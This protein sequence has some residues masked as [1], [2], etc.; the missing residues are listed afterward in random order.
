MMGLNTGQQVRIERPTANGTT[1]AL[2][3]I[4]GAHDEEPNSVFLDYKDPE[5]VGKRF[6]LPTIRPFQGKTNAQVVAVG[7][8]DAEAEAY[9]EFI[10]HLADDDHNS[11]LVVIAPHGGDLEEHTDEQ[12]E[13]VAEQLSSKRVSVWMCKGFKKGGGAFDRW[14]ITSTDISQESFPKL[15]TIYG[16]HFKYAIAFHG[17]GGDSICIGGSEPNPDNPDCQKEEISLKEEIKCAIE[18]VVPGSIDV[19]LGGAGDK[20]CPENFNGDNSENIVNR[21]ATT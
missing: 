13:H 4:S 18:K 6:G 3:T 20:G 21:L 17:W 1:L 2:Y 7:L 16:R 19:V 15:K 11:E 8:T 9:S 5:D 12:A 14:H 10:E